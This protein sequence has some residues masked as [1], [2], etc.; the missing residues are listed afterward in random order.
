MNDP[1]VALDPTVLALLSIFGGAAFTVAAGSIG[2]WIQ[3]RREHQAWLR[4]QRYL[5]YLDYLKKKDKYDR[6]AVRISHVRHVFDSAASGLPPALASED[7][8]LEAIR[9]LTDIGEGV[10]QVRERLR[11]QQAEFDELYAELYE[12]IAA[13]SLLGPRSVIDAA[14]A[15]TRAEPG[16]RGPQLNALE[17]AMREAL[18]IAI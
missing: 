5:A 8:F 6:E 9:D 10:D 4:E 14:R 2:A 13:F 12:A 18:S 1:T 15:L 7:Q 16:E 11:A 17:S 3:S